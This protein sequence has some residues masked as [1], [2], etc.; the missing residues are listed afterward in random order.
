MEWKWIRPIG[1]CICHWENCCHS[2]IKTKKQQ[3]CQ[4]RHHEQLLCLGWYP[5]TNGTSSLNVRV[6]V[7]I[8][9]LFFF[10]DLVRY[11]VLFSS[12]QQ[13]L[14]GTADINLP[15]IKRITPPKIEPPESENH[16]QRIVGLYLY[17]AFQLLVFKNIPN[18]APSLTVDTINGHHQQQTGFIFFQIPTEKTRNSDCHFPYESGATHQKLGPTIKF[19]RNNGA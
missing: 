4:W 17:F 11:F 15:E 3:L 14:G 2:Q 16:I 5:Q 13:G 6:R 12:I 19:L 10:I 8:F 1:S 9:I 18:T 7:W